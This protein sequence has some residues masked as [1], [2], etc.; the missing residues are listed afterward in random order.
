MRLHQYVI[1][2]V[3][4]KFSQNVSEDIV[5]QILE[6]CGHK[7]WLPILKVAGGAKNHLPFILLSDLGDVIY[8]M[9]L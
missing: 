8:T 5:D 3:Y 7:V 6:Y 9:Q 4:Y 1:N 2:V